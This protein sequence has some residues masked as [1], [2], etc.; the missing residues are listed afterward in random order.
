[1]RKVRIAQIGTSKM[2]HGNPVF[3]R[4][5]DNPDVFEVVGVCFPEKEDEKWPENMAQFEGYKR[6]TLDE[7]LN[8]ETIEAVTVE[9]EEI[10]LTKYALMCAKHNKHIHMEKPG[11]IDHKEFEELISV[12]KETGK[13]FHTGYMY[14]YNPFVIELLE[15][16]KKGELGDIISVEAQMCTPPYGADAREW[17]GVFPDGMLYFLGCP[18]IDLVYS[19]KGKPE[20]VYP[21]SRSTNVEGVS[22]KDSGLCL[23]EY[24]SGMSFVKTCAYEFG[25]PMRRQLSVVGT[26]KTVEIRPLEADGPASQSA[27]RKVYADKSWVAP[28]V[29]DTAP[30]FDRYKGMLCSFAAM[31]RGEKTN[32]YTLDYELELHKLILECCSSEV[33]K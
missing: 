18:L 32:P 15:D 22:T 1:M 10:Y 20:K 12:M 5:I 25:G 4:L 28:P 13:V 23:M 31:V 9:T 11:G 6:L 26:K 14:R 7:I 30:R 19:I 2:S 33:E 3:K 21:M 29:F 27:H 8:D 16:I 17:L 24:K